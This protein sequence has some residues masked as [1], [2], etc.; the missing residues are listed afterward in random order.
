MKKDPESLFKK[1]LKSVAASVPVAASLA[2]WW[3]EMDSDAQEEAI[4]ELKEE[5]NG[6]RNPIPFSHPKAIEALK[7][8]FEKIELTGD[9]H[10]EMDNDLK[11][12]LE[13][14][15]LWEKQNLISGQHEIG[16]RWLS[17]YID[18]PIFI[19]AVFSAKY[20]DTATAELRQYVWNFIK[21]KKKGV[22]GESIAK[23]KDVPLPYVDALFSIFESEGKGWKSKEIGSSYFSPDPDLC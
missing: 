12:F 20:G 15:S 13:V 18:N 16:H 7:L 22:H 10:W 8:I 2:Q 4:D 6:L 19:L 14:L 23:D 11:Q 5:I 17:I 9:I 1:S 21:Q 3:S